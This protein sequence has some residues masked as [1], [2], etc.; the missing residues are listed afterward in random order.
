MVR[1]RTCVLALVI[2]AATL[3]SGLVAEESTCPPNTRATRHACVLDVDITISETLELGS[4]TTLDCHGHRILPLTMGTGTSAATYVPSVPEA[5]IIITGDRDVNLQ[6]CTIGQTGSRFDFGIIAID[7]KNPGDDGHHIRDNEIHVRDSGITFLRVDD[8]KVNNNVITWTNGVGIA[9]RRDSDRNRVVRNNLSSPGAPAMPGRVVP[10][11]L[12]VEADDGIAV[13]SFPLQ[14]LHNIIVGGR[15]YQFP[16]SH[17]GTYEGNDDNV[18]T[19]NYLSLPGSSVGKSHA[20]IYV[21]TNSKGTRVINNEVVQAGVGIRPAGLMQAQTVQRAARCVDMNGLAVNRFCA[22][23]A[24]CSIPGIDPAPVGICPLLVQEVVDLRAVGTLI[25]G[26]ML[27]GPFNSANAMLRTAIGPGQGTVEGVIR[28]NV[29]NGTGV[30]AGI[31]LGGNMIQTGTVTRNIVRGTAVGLLLVQAAS[32]QF[33]ARVFLN[34]FRGLTVRGV[35]TF[36]TYT[37]PTELSWKRKG[38][39][40]GHLVPPC[41]AVT[42]GP[43]PGLVWDSNPFCSPVAE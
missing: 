18:V 39:F 2:V 36:G 27:T 25:Q 8:A 5:A 22:T 1:L 30:E 41:F 40:W 10:D 16:N 6:N 42:D 15:L 23:S 3:G 26:N 24:D 33:G 11:G 35:D 38:N 34:D 29:I 9:I 4:F 32:T 19:G 43:N 14:V 28:D 7:S 12:F 37:L 17:D 31:V 13:A 21:A 20:A